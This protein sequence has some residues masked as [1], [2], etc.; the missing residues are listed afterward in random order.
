[1][2]KKKI[3]ASATPTTADVPALTPAASTVLRLLDAHDGTTAADLAERSSLGRSTVTKSLSTLHEAGLAVR[4]EGGHEGTRRIADR[5]FAALGSITPAADADAEGQTADFQ[6]L[7]AP[8]A[9]FVTA[10]DEDATDTISDVAPD[11]ADDDVT[12]PAPSEFEATDYDTAQNKRLIG[13]QE[14]PADADAATEDDPDSERNEDEHAEEA[15]ED[16]AP[17]DETLHD[18]PAEAEATDTDSARP[19]R[20]DEADAETSTYADSTATE[21]DDSP[22]EQND[23]NGGGSDDERDAEP[24]PPATDE[25]PGGPDA[26]DG[27]APEPES[28][29]AKASSPRLGKGELR[30]QVEAHLSAHPKQA[31][32]PTQLHHVLSRSSGAIANACDKLVEAEKAVVATDKPRRFQW[33]PA[34][35]PD[36]A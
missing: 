24:L 18:E 11:N 14:E 34:T 33:K 26:V 6:G 32:T 27:A 22:T 8:A 20:A 1:M 29:E 31:F 10:A 13:E 30:A 23:V 25:S 4:Q 35:E 17:D 7:A 21:P 36:T 19:G 15:S 16:G 12:A 2:P 28:A 3:T 5:W 9:P